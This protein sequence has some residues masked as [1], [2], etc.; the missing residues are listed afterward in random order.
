MGGAGEFRGEN[1]LAGPGLW[2]RPRGRQHAGGLARSA[3]SRPVQ[4]AAV[5]QGGTEG[6]S[7]AGDIGVRL[8][9]RHLCPSLPG[10]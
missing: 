8:D 5:S 7:G 4:A 1:V 6:F 9:S 10:K 3:G 2:G